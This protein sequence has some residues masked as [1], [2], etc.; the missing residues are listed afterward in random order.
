MRLSVVDS[1]IFINK[2]SQ[3][4]YS[5]CCMNSLVMCGVRDR[6]R[7]HESSCCSVFD[8]WALGPYT[9]LESCKPAGKQGLSLGSIG[10]I[11]FTRLRELQ[12]QVKWKTSPGCL[13]MKRSS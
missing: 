11:G 1:T 9:M 7:W 6:Q 10:F 4:S 13:G 8:P 3:S 2:L 5:S 12:H